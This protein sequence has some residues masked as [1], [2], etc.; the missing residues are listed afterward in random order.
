MANDALKALHTAL[1]DARKGYEQARKATGE[2]DVKAIFGKMIGLHEKSHDSIHKILASRGEKPD[3]DGSFMSMVH[4]TV[5]SVRSAIT[6]LDKNSL[7]SFA[8]GEE[9]IVQSYDEAI[10]DSLGDA[11]V[12]KALKRQRSDFVEMIDQMQ[13]LAA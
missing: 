3:D 6:G 5:I 10:R 7:S 2:A 8:S 12:V 13:R 4:T 1:I 11:A 9:R